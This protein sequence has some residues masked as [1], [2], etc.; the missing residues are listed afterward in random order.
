M[1]NYSIKPLHWEQQAANIH[2]WNEKKMK[3]KEGSHHLVKTKVSN[4]GAR[5]H[6]CQA[7]KCRVEKTL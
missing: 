6:V 7:L 3:K 5:R 2:E 1:K 4:F